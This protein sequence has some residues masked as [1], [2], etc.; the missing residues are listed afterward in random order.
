MSNALA[1]SLAARRQLSRGASTLFGLI[2]VAAF[3]T[4]GTAHADVVNCD[5][6]CIWATNSETGMDEALKGIKEL[7]KP[8]FAGYSGYKLINHP[9]LTLAA[10]KTGET[11]LTDKYKLSIAFGGTTT[12]AG[13]EK[14][15]L[16]VVVPPGRLDT[17]ISSPSGKRFFLAGLKH[18][19]GILILGITCSRTD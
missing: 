6:M 7:K 8:P 9:S 11:A 19:D 13:K 2:L 4:A 12:D 16:H 15:A 3:W 5:I 18:K 1:P 14:L 10:G 17:R